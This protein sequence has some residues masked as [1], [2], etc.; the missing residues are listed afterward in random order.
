[1]ETHEG[2]AKLLAQLQGIRANLVLEDFDYLLE[3]CDELVVVNF[4]DKC[5]VNTDD[6]IEARP[7]KLDG[8]RVVQESDQ[9]DSSV[10]SDRQIVAQEALVEAIEGVTKPVVIGKGEMGK[11]SVDPA[12]SC[13]H[14]GLSA[15]QLDIHV[16]FEQRLSIGLIFLRVGH[17]LGEEA[18]SM[19]ESLTVANLRLLLL[20]M[21]DQ[22]VQ[23]ASQ[24]LR[25][26]V[27]ARLT[28]VADG[29][30]ELLVG[31]LDITGIRHID[32]KSH[33]LNRILSP[34]CELSLLHDEEG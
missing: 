5:K 4:I 31:A 3:R 34:E 33:K 16:L 14:E 19:E 12:G 8:Y 9:R 15:L 32:L 10:D 2:L 7:N 6:L 30:D 20:K 18:K 28:N 26:L 23:V 29:P 21:F 11:L 27:P 22:K 25:N 17:V 24:V 1:M 13:L